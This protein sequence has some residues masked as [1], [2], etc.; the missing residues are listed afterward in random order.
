MIVRKTQKQ[1][2]GDVLLKLKDLIQGVE[3]VQM[4]PGL[5]H[6]R[7]DALETDIKGIAYDSRR[8]KKGDIFVCISGYK[9]DGHKFV[10]D[11]MKNGALAFIVENKIHEDI[12]DTSMVIEVEDSRKALSKISSNYFQNPTENLNIFGVTGTNGKTT[13]TYLIKQILEEAHVSCALL[14][15][16]S[17]QIGNKEYDSPNTTPESFELQ[18]MF[19]EMNA[20]NIQTCVME[21]S[22]HSLALKRVEDVDF[23]FGIF[24]NLTSD[25]LEFHNNF[26]HYYQAKKKLFYK[27]EKANLINIDD[28]YGNKMSLELREE[29]DKP[30]YTYAIHKKADFMAENIKTA[31][32]FSS[33]DLLQDGKV[34]G[35][36]TLPIPGMF[37]VYNALAAASTCLL[38]GIHFD[39]IKASLKSIKGVPGRFEVVENKRDILVIV[40]YAHTPD[41][42]EKVLKTAN[43]FKKGRLIC[44]FG[45]G[46]DRDRSKRPLMGKAAGGLSDYCIIT[47]DNP[48]NESPEQIFNDTEAGVAPTGCP[49]EIIEVRLEAIKRAVEI[50][51]K[52]DIILLAG[53]GHETYQVIGNQSIHFDDRETVLKIIESM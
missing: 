50:Y 45:C 51:R 18:K 4:N 10:H 23:D 24:T 20:E 53:K 33:F 49:Y 31:Q 43:G 29:L 38:A 6:L 48:R 22:S 34:L 15:T 44:V 2:K 28:D 13:I 14:G 46:G 52:N 5:N 7:N 36:I 47:S 41:A 30:C 27:T 35:N 39:Q 9:T 1:N 37:S 8:V 12:Y 32:R 40:D 25:H 16:I 3:M 19:K 26:D 11:A 17:Y 21:V 42:L